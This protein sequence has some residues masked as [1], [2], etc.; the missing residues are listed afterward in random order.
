MMI[1][2]ITESKNNTQREIKEIRNCSELY[3]RDTTKQ[4]FKIPYARKYEVRHRYRDES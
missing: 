3:N 1:V 4:W 2:K